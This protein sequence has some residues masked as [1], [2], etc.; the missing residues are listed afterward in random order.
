[1]NRETLFES[2][3][4]KAE[5]AIK[6]M[7]KQ[8]IKDIYA[9]SFWKDNLEDDPRCPVITIGYNTLTQVEVAKRN[10]SSLMEAKWNYAFWLQNEVG[11]IGGN[12]K[13]L[14]L[15]FKEANLFYTQQEYSRAEKNGEENKL[16]EQDDQMQL[17]FMDII[18]SVIQELHKKGVIKEQLGKEEHKVKEGS[19]DADKMT[20][21]LSCSNNNLAYSFNNP[22]KYSTIVFSPDYKISKI[23]EVKDI[24]KQAEAEYLENKNIICVYDDKK[25]KH[26]S[27]EAILNI[28]IGNDSSK[29]NG[30]GRIDFHIIGYGVD[31]EEAIGNLNIIYID[32]MNKFYELKK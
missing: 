11:T 2:F 12:D 18:I 31:K 1:M 27:Y 15:Y 9:I 17:V 23:L 14:R 10:A 20:S 4:T 30:H 21:V 25:E 6:K 16:D 8:N 19:I 32:I 5:K 26:N 28:D 3:Y 22:P 24:N 29:A 13:N 7:G